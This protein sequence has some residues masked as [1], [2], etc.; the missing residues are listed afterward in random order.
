M[1]R[2]I[3]CLTASLFTFSTSAVNWVSLGEEPLGQSFMDL[4]SI[5]IVDEYNSIVIAYDK[6]ALGTAAEIIHKR[7]YKCKDKSTN[8]LSYQSYN[9]EEIVSGVMNQSGFSALTGPGT[10]IYRKWAIACDAFNYDSR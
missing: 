6:L 3:V 1:K 4:D 9:S 8:I 7:A 2:L 10:P 5:K